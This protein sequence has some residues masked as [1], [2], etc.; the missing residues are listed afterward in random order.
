M[1]S[2]S[3]P[4]SVWAFSK[5]QPNYDPLKEYPYRGWEDLYRKEWTWDSVGFTTHA[6]GCVAGC[7]WKVYVKN[8]MPMRDEQVSEYPQLPGI[9]DMN[10]RG[11]QKGPAACPSPRGRCCRA[12][13][14]VCA[15]HR[16]RHF[17]RRAAGRPA[18]A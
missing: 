17:Q 9:P 6:I 7:A 5:I 13:G 1:A 18:T 3:V 10:P 12:C 2:M 8:G 16:W 14:R 11:C 15:A 4:G